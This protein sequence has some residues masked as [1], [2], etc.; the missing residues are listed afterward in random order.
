M[1]ALSTLGFTKTIPIFV[2]NIIGGDPITTAV[3]CIVNSILGFAITT[4]ILRAL[5]ASV[6]N[7]P[8]YVITFV[9]GLTTLYLGYT[10]I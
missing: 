2:S 3:K 7:L 6:L 1:L 8:F 5:G 10:K 9:L 4:T